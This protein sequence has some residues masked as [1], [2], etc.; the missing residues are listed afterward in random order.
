MVRKKAEGWKLPMEKV[1]AHTS[2]SDYYS[3]F[4]RRYFE[5]TFHV[6]PTSFLSPLAKRL[7]PGARI[8]DAGCGSGRD[9][10]WLK[11]R[12]FE[13]MGFERSS[14]LAALAR[15]HA[16]CRV[17]E[18]DFESYD[19]SNLSEDAIALVGALVHI[20]HDRLPDVFGRI[21]TALRPGGIV[22]VSLKQGEGAAPAADGRTFYLWRDADIRAVFR[23]FGFSVAEFF[24]QRSLVRAGDVWMGYVLQGGRRKCLTC[25]VV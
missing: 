14:G 13:V 5:N 6:D 10:R 11:Q 20:P 19:F 21:C 18:G 25:D 22:L 12:G 16:G 7:P 4:S 17:I 23:Q 24:V 2:E 9:L 3:R 15:E 8:L 1:M